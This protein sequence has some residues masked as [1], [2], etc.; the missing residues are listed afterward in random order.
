MG[1]IQA[2]HFFWGTLGSLEDAMVLVE[3]EPGR[4]QLHCGIWLS[5]CG[6]PAERVEA[7]QRGLTAMADRALAGAE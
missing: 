6:L 5:T 7:L 3:M 4:D 2:P 1:F